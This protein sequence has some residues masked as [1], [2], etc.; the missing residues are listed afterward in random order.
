MI[1]L[2][3]SVNDSIDTLK[4]IG[5]S[6]SDG[7]YFDIETTGFSAG[8]S[9]VYLIGC[10]YPENGAF[11]GIQWLSQ[12]ASDEYL[13][14]TAF[15]KFIQSYRY[16]IHFN[17]DGFD[18]PYLIQRCFRLSLNYNFDNIISIDL[19]KRIKP[20]KKFLKLENYKQK[21]LEKFAGI[22]RDDKFN[23]GE[24]INIYRNYVK[25]Q[26]NDA[27]NCIILHNREDLTGMIS[28][29]PVLS[30]C[31]I[32]DGSFHFDS[33]ELYDTEIII[34]LALDIPVLQRISLKHNDFYITA[35]E[36]T[37]KLC[38]KIL[39]GELK[40]FYKNYRDYYYLPA[41]D[42]AIHKSVAVYVDREFCKKAV[43]SNCYIRKTG[44]FIPQLTEIY[45]PCFKSDY[46]DKTMY[47]ELNDDFLKDTDAVYQYVFDIIKAV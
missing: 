7:I 29:L 30:Y 35:Y 39:E 13:I 1:T 32:T 19:F 22:N 20:I 25:T 37:M 43:P 4:Y 8:N 34:N 12:S 10:I 5:I 28:I 14:I 24:L 18:I 15:F 45:T 33:Y 47:I 27:F 11:K 40:Y 42:T 16:L 23:G 31:K 9:Q 3:F 21:S 36:S 6:Q 2:D 17:G 38:I 26:D 46:S 41:E 44:R